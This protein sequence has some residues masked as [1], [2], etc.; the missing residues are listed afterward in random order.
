M[1]WITAAGLLL[2]AIFAAQQE[3]WHPR[4]QHTPHVP[5]VSLHL[6]IASKKP[7]EM[8]VC[9]SDSRDKLN[10]AVNNIFKRNSFASIYTLL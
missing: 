9:G 6:S 8:Q 1:G 4:T 3:W 5:A 7:N 2:E 10:F